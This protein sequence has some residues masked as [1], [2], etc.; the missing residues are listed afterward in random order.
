MTTK[1]FVSLGDLAKE[2]GVN[3]SKLAFYVKLGLLT[4][5][6]TAGRVN[7]YDHTDALKQI[8]KIKD[9]QKSKS[10]TLAGIKQTIK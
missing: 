9:L 10:M 5:V 4:S 7:I 1:K 6:S 3:K 2:L 8:K